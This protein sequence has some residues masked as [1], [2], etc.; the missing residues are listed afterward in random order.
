MKRFSKHKNA[1]LEFSCTGC[2]LCCKEAGYVFFSDNDIK[3]AS[4]LL[5]ISPIVFINKYL[6]YEENYG[7]YI[8]VTNEKACIFLDEYNKCTI[9]DAKPEQCKTFPYWNEYM[10][11]NGNIIAG[12]FNRPC[13]GITIK[14]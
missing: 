12:K 14:K 9:Q 4:A 5:K 2:G 13:P 8:Q 11:K 7:Y 3:R 6:E 1:V 10:D